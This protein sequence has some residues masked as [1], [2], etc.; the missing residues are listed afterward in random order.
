MSGFYFTFM[1]RVFNTQQIDEL[2]ENNSDQYLVFEGNQPKFMALDDLRYPQSSEDSST[3][4]IL[5][6]GGA[7]YIGSHVVTELLRAGLHPIILDNLSNS[8]IPQFACPFIVGDLEN[9]ELLNKIFAQNQIVA[10]VH[11][12]GSLIVEESVLLPEK[13]FHN[14]IVNGINL[15]NTMLRHGVNK[16]VFSSSAAVYG[17]PR[18]VPIDEKHPMDPTNPYGETKLIFE[19]IV[20]WYSRAHDLSAVMFR[21]FNAAGADAQGQIGEQHAIETHLIP[22]ILQVAN[23]ES[24][25]VKIFG[26]DYP[27]SDGTAVRDYVHV[28]DIAAAH[29][30]AIKKLFNDS[31]VFVYNIG[32]GKGYSVAEIVD[33]VVEITNRMVPI[34]QHDRRAGDPPILVAD[35]KKVHTE[36]GLDLKYSDLDTI[37]KTA[38]AWHKKRF[39]HQK[40]TQTKLEEKTAD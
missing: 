25:A 38:W 10:V 21:Y 35:N 5:V 36:L 31:G 11:L 2:L 39:A 15:L 20:N 22:K 9:T 6:T 29:V 37:I 19:K 33:K 8:S 16:L 3:P 13:Y 26:H 1:P 4:S 23:K 24:D 27:T 17:S 14:N 7:G 32:T 40:E 12:A 30:L 18:Y 28:S 34:E